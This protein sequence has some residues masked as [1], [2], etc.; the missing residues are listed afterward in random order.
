MSSK[1][2]IPWRREDLTRTGRPVRYSQQ[3]LTH[4]AFP[5]G[6][7]GT[8]SVS[9][10]GW[11]QLR[12]FEL[13]NRPAFGFDP[14]FAFFTLKLKDNGKVI[15]RVLQGPP[16]N[17]QPVHDGMTGKRSSGEGLPHFARNT[18]ESAFPFACVNLEDNQVPVTVK[19]EA[20][21]PFIP[22]DDTNSSIPTAILLYEVTNT[23]KRKL[24]GAIY[25]TLPNLAGGS[26]PEG[27]T[28]ERKDDELLSGLW[29]STSKYG[30]EDP[31]F[32]T[33]ALATP[34]DKTIIW[35]RWG[36]HPQSALQQFWD[37][38]ESPDFDLPDKPLPGR[39]DVGTLGIPFTLE[40]GDSI[41]IPFILT[42]HF[43][44]M[45]KYWT[46]GADIQS[47][48]GPQKS[49]PRWHTYTDTLW[50]DAWE[51][52]RHVVEN[53]E[54]LHEE[55]WKFSH[56][57]QQSTLPDIVKD[58]VT[59]TL[60]VLKSPTCLRLEDGTFYGFE[61]CHDEKGCCE[62][63]CTHVWNYAQSLAALFPDLQ[64]SQLNA[65][66]KYAQDSEGRQDFR[67]PL[68]MGILSK[69]LFHPAADGQMGI[70]IQVYREWQNTGD[71]TW[72]QEVWPFV[73]Q[74][75]AYAWKYWDKDRDGVMEGMQHNTYDVEFY[76]PNPLCTGLYLT[77][78]KT[79]GAMA[80]H[81]GDA[82][83]AAECQRLFQ[84]GTQKMDT[85]L[86][87][88]EYYI[89]KINP[90]AHLDWPEPYQK[91]TLAQGQDTR[92]EGPRYQ[93]GEGCLID[94]L[95]GYWYSKNLGLDSGL[96]EQHVK[97]ALSSLF[98]YNWKP[99]M[100]GHPITYR[101][102]A[103]DGEAGLLNCTWPKGNRPGYPLYYFDEV[104]TG[105]EYQAAASMIYSGMV[106]EGLA[107]VNSVRE[108][109]RGDNR[110]PWD[111]CECGHHYARALSAW[112]LLPA[113]SGVSCSV[114]GKWLKIAPVIRPERFSAPL[115]MGTAWGFYQQD[116]R[117]GLFTASLSMAGGEI[118]LHELTLHSVDKNL[119][120]VKVEH[121]E[122]PVS[123]KMTPNVTGFRII[124]SR[125]I[126]LEMDDELS[127]SIQ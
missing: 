29:Y 113:L 1:P 8:G 99:D 42:W 51:V 54:G 102:Y 93:Q 114:P 98:K 112:S 64:K 92:L 123:V 80:N 53:L 85:E 44:V 20:F 83:L 119:T 122:E 96:N 35:P 40:S 2:R 13:C 70:L 120:R 26:D 111:E 39:W 5:L 9:L 58:S 25:G 14:E 103:S 61:G 108:R 22:M 116:L 10:G 38:M 125:D 86:F 107:V 62:G 100:T 37:Y 11:G 18:F 69:H 76:G 3:F 121:N 49:R 79:V 59:H 21:N 52:A 87:N 19:L 82:E 81:L 67:Q 6:G 71:D 57:F 105:L 43:P 89:Q 75:L 45:E 7:I 27:K 16:R 46:D 63:T 48:C 101:R 23:S 33:M 104:W 72:L 66:F 73:K 106:E 117:K 74:A 60:S 110:N 115:F 78:L 50:A 84:S 94:Q 32:G 55:S 124:F 41:T 91:L 17:P 56:S 30:P 47:C 109:Y 95:L 90:E 28:A 126:T 97:S 34:F 31:R 4:L 12:D 88:G 77:A 68:P 15:S 118:T 127:I 24:E 65:R 36:G